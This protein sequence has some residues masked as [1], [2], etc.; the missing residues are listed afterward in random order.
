MSVARQ[1]TN[2]L[3]YLER[4]FEIHGELE[5]VVYRTKRNGEQE[6]YPYE[7]QS[8][9]QW[10]PLTIRN[11]WITRFA[12][13]ISNPNE[14]E[15]DVVARKLFYY[16]PYIMPVGD[17]KFKSETTLYIRERGEY[18]LVWNGSPVG[19]KRMLGKRTEVKFSFE[20]TGAY[21]L[22]CYFQGEI[23]CERQFMITN[24]DL[25]ASYE[26]WLAAHLAEIM[27]LPEPEYESVKTYRRGMRS[28]GN[29]L[30]AVDGK[31]E[32][33]VLYELPKLKY[34]D[35]KK[36]PPW[37]YHRRDY[38][39]QF[40]E[41]TRIFDE[42]MLEVGESWQSLSDEQKADW[43]D[44]AEAI[45]RQYGKI[46]KHPRLTGFNLYTREYLAGFL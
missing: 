30:L 2:K 27:E 6:K 35:G 37:V 1:E 8:Y 9:Y 41:Q 29:W 45:W 18:K 36:Q 13:Q 12:C 42:K 5:G 33:E 34:K 23:Y 43:E 40:N 3:T 17:W 32:K 38:D 20:E 7:P 31:C 44:R 10:T 11:Q 14:T 4:Y 26:T 25:D 46:L 16:T 21:S 15:Y 24:A 28:N 22:K 39:H 19:E